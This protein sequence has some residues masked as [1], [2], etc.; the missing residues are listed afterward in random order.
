MPSPA[1]TAARAA[2]AAARTWVRD[3]RAALEAALLA[4][5]RAEALEAPVAPG[6]DVVRAV[7]TALARRAA[8]DVVKWAKR[9]RDL[10]MAP[11]DVFFPRDCDTIAEFARRRL[12][13]D[14][15]LNA[16][17]IARA[18][19]EDD[20]IQRIMEHTIST[21]LYATARTKDLKAYEAERARKRQRASPRAA[22]PPRAH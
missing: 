17:A 4:E 20:D 3:A 5:A 8:E 1:L 12:A 7:A 21:E 14:P 18:A 10:D 2:T 13:A 15:A 11:E 9:P 16:A 22:S 6:P 19:L